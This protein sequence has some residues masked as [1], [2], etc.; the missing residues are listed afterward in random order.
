VLLLSVAIALVVGSFGLFGLASADSGTARQVEA[1]VVT[2]RP[3]AGASAMEVVTFTMDGAEHEAK[4]DGCGHQSDE[5]VLV[6]VGTGDI[7]HAAEAAP[8]QGH[9]GRRLDLLLL[10]VSGVAGAAYGILVR[11][12]PRGTPLPLGKFEPAG[13]K[14]LMP[15][16]RG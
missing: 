1:H 2:G 8:G 9:Y 11:R 10:V 15:R 3:C 16:R 7:V 5:P 6:T 4:F 14:Q 12:G 13:L